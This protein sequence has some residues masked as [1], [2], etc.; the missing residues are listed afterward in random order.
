MVRDVADLG[1]Q[2][3]SSARSHS[4]STTTR[5]GPL[6]STDDLDIA[7]RLHREGRPQEAVAVLEGVVRKAGSKETWDRMKA[8]EFL[9]RIHLEAGK[10]KEAERVLKLAAADFERL[11]RDRAYKV[12]CPYQALGALYAHTGK[13]TSAASY[14]VKAATLEPH[15]E[16]MQYDAALE[17]M[18]AGDFL[19]AKK[20]M[21]RAIALS[22]R[23]RQ[24]TGGAARDHPNRYLVLKGFILLPLRKY[25]EARRM[26]S[27]VLAAAPDDAG[28]RAGLGHLAVVRKQ[29]A[30]AT[31]HLRVA[32]KGGK[33]LLA[34]VAPGP[35]GRPAVDSLRD[36]TQI[37]GW[38]C[39]RMASLGLGWVAANKGRHEQ[40]LGYFEGTLAHRPS[41]LL[42]LLGKG[43]SLNALGQLDR[44]ATL[45]EKL[46]SAYPDN[47]YVLA[48]QALVQ[49]NKNNH[50]K[51]E[52]GFKKAARLGHK[53]YTCPY[54]GLGLVYLRRGKLA[55]AKANFKRAIANNPDIEFKK[56][57]GLA[58]I[59]IKEGRL[60][61]ARRLLKKSMANY[62]Y[63][64]EAKKL[65]A[66]LGI[67]AT[68]A[69]PGGAGDPDGVPVRPPIFDDPARKI[70]TGRPAVTGP[71]SR[72]RVVVKPVTGPALRHQVVIGQGKRCRITASRPC[73]WKDTSRRGYSSLLV[74][75]EKLSG[76]ALLLS[77]P[78]AV[79][80]SG[81]G[82]A[83]TLV[84]ETGRE[85]RWRSSRHGLTYTRL[86]Q[87]TPSGTA[88][89]A[90]RLR[91]TWRVLCSGGSGLGMELT[92]TNLGSMK[93]PMVE[94]IVC[95]AAIKS[96]CNGLPTF[97]S[98]RGVRR[99]A[100]VQSG[101][102]RIT[103]N[104]EIPVKGAPAP[105]WRGTRAVTA[106][107]ADLGL[108]LQRNPKRGWIAALGWDRASSLQ[109]A[110]W[111]CIHS[112]PYVA[113]LKPG[114]KVTRRGWVYLFKG[115]KEALLQAFRRD[116]GR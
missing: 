59:L 39:H 32:L 30:A 67:G 94:A 63:D 71:A 15:S 44:A 29:Y 17:S 102:A 60:E 108:M 100:R 27:R 88:G 48:E 76:G 111:E 25:D 24:P 51:A 31:A 2:E 22:R 62:P 56:Y 57:N 98:A 106:R 6:P 78:E 85:P 114:Q 8:R 5:R 97:T 79:R 110:A 68:A 61:E 41:D 66:S 4:P 54:E 7:R 65:L 16:K 64:S 113:G 105:L 33:E 87:T 95:L 14:F 11:R 82:K 9:G 34:V 75:H 103:S 53:K 77:I 13:Q 74:R 26:F 72:D 23:P 37:Y 96:E 91:T 3:P 49:L 52:A 90:V 86:W 45:F 40:A 89:Q 107:V 36:P 83:V 18:V 112:H 28:A 69:P 104:A 115:S 35:R 58:R 38:L 1:P 20:F 55:L 12:A 93:L 116:L 50:Q 109:Y 70:S 92:L 42:A 21:E 101:W 10:F 73:A 19:T 84:A 81:G 80:V 99:W 46:A 47:P 43:N